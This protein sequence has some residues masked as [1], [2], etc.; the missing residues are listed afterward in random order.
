MPRVTQTDTR[1]IAIDYAV[2]PVR[3]FISTIV[4]GPLWVFEPRKPG[5]IV[6]VELMW[7][8]NSSGSGNFDLVPIINQVDVIGG[9]VTV[10]GAKSAGDRDIGPEPTDQR[11]FTE[12]DTIGISVV[13][14]AAYSGGTGIITFKVEYGTLGS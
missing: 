10:T 4:N 5:R 6:G 13:E 8:T 12:D 1:R 7:T 11:N 14:T 2:Y 3:T 9:T